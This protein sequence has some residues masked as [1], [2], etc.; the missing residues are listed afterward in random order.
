MEPVH[1]WLADSH[2]PGGRRQDTRCCLTDLPTLCVRRY[3][4]L[5]FGKNAFNVCIREG[6]TRCV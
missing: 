2:V 3:P 1:R 5:A 6:L 4:I